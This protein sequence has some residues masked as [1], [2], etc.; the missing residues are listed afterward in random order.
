MTTLVANIRRIAE[1]LIL[2]CLVMA[3]MPAAAQ[4]PINPT[5]LSVKEEQLLIDNKRIVGE[6]SLPDRKA[7]TLE[8]PRGQDWRYYYETWLRLLGGL[9]IVG[10]I[11]IVILF[12]LVRGPIKMEHGRTGRVMTRFSAIE[13]FAHWMA[14]TCFILLALSGLNITFGKT[15]IL[16]LLGPEAFAKM[17]IWGKYAHNYLSFPFTLSV[18]M[19]FLMWVRWNLPSLVDLEW[20]KQGGG[21]GKEHPPADLF[22]AGQKS[23]F[24]VV[25]LGGGLVAATGYLLMLPFFF[26]G[27]VGM[28]L[29][30]W[31]H[32]GV[33]LLYIAAIVFHIY[34]GTVGEEGALEGMWHGTVDENWAKQH[35]SIW[36]EREVSKGNIS[37]PPK[38]EGRVQ[39]AE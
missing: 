28:Q 6:C 25:V 33:A 27:I 29:A 9:A 35:H 39:P 22:N 1:A 36:Y 12:Y 31:V 3:A 17:T 30:Q 34:M 32:V 8:Q 13:R 37:V 26:T 23:I 19:I 15:L 20:F 5:D 18:I 14:T 10:M 11:G 7:C 2:A 16:P 24:W 21:F 4:Q 38:P